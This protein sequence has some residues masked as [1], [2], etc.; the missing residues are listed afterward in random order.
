MGAEGRT[1][2]D[3]LPASHAG[4][5]ESEPGGVNPPAVC[6]RGPTR[7]LERTDG[8]RAAIV[9]RTPGIAPRRAVWAMS[10]AWRRPA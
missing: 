6:S 7:P 4:L 8:W 1:S 9:M 3:P 10:A 2:A 5:I